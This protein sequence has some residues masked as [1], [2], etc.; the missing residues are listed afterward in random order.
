MQRVETSNRS[1]FGREERV[2]VE[3]VLKCFP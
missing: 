2:C 3:A 1:S